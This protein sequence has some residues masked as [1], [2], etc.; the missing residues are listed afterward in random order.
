[1]NATLRRSPALTAFIGQR[2]DAHPEKVAY[3]FL[4]DGAD[5]TLTLT[6]GQ[7]DRQARAIA[8]QLSA[9][10][11]P[12]D[13]AVLLYPPGLEYITALCGCFYAGLIAVPAYPPQSARMDRA[14]PRRLRAI[15]ADARPAL[16]LTTSSG[17]AL[18]AA[19]REHDP[20]FSTLAW[21][22][23]DTLDPA[24]ADGWAEPRIDDSAIA[25]LQYTSGSTAAPKGVMLSHANLVH[26]LRQIKAAFAVTEESRG[27]CWL[28]PYHDMGLIGGVL[29]P[30]F[31]GATTI[32]MSPLAF[33]QR[34]LRWLEAISQSRTTISGGPNFA[35]ELCVRKTTPEQRATLDLSSWRVAFTGAEPIQAA[36][37]R[38][39]AE[40]FAPS[41][42]RAEAFYPCYGLAE[43]TLI[44][45]GGAPD[46]PPIMR[47][48]DA[49]ALA[50]HRVQPAPSADDGRLLVGCGGAV[51]DQQIAIVDPASGRR[52]ESGQIGE[53]W[54]Q[55]PSV[56]QGYWDKPELS[57]ET[58]QAQ[59]A[60]GNDERFL[61]TGDLGFLDGHELFVTGRIKDLII[62]R[63]RNHYP[64]DI[65]LSAELSH[66]ALR[67]GSGAAFAVEAD[68]EER[69]IVVH[70]LERQRL[71]DDP[72]PI[73]EAIRRAVA[74][75]HQI[76]PYAV[77]LL[78]PGSLPKT[79]SGKIQR[80][81]CRAAYLDGALDAVAADVQS[82]ELDAPPLADDAPLTR[83]TLLALPIDERALLLRPMLQRSIA[84]TLGVAADQIAPHAPLTALGLDSLTATE[85]QQTIETQLQVVTPMT[86]FL[87]GPS[88]AELAAEIA[89]ALDDAPTAS[90]ALAPAPTERQP[91]SAGQRSLWLL[92][93]LAPDSAA[94]NIPVAARIHGPIDATRL[95]SALAD[96]LARHDELRAAFVYGDATTNGAPIRQIIASPPRA[97]TMLDARGWSDAALNAHLSAEA[98]RPF[99]LS[100]PP[101]LR[102]TLATR[103][104][105]EHVLLIVAH[106]IVADLW[107]LL[108]LARELT[109]LYQQPDAPSAAGLRYADYAAAH[110]QRLASADGE[111]LWQFWQR[112]LADAPTALDLPT[113][114]PRPPVQTFRGAAHA[115]RLDPQLSA[116]VRALGEREGATPFMTLLAA[117][118]VLLQRYTQQT[119]LLVGVPTAG[120]TRAELGDTIGYFI[121]P[122]VLRAHVDPHDSFRALLADVRRT[123]LD[124]L[125]HQEYPFVSLVERLQ[126][127]RDPSRSPL[128]QVMFAWQKMPLLDALGLTGFAFGATGRATQ[129]G[130]F[131]V[132]PWPLEQRAA[133]FDLSLAMGELDQQL[134]GALEYNA[135][136]FDAVT[137]ER[138]IGHFTTLLSAIVAAPEQ[139][140]GTLPLL[141]P[142]EERL[143]LHEWN[144]AAAPLPDADLFALIAAQAARTPD[145]VALIYDDEQISYGALIERAGR[146]GAYLRGRGV[147][148]SPQ[149]ESIV[150]VLLE[151]SID[152]MAAILGV[153]HAGGC[154]VPLDPINPLDRL[155]WLLDDAGAALLLTSSALASVAPDRAICLDRD[156][157]AIASAS[158]VEPRAA[159][160]NQ[161]AAIIY[162][163]GSTGQPKGVVLEQRSLVNLVASFAASYAPTPA[164]RILPLT[165]LASASF[166]GEIF[167]LL[168]AGGALVLPT[169]TE[170]LD[171]TALFA[172]LER[173]AVSIVST[174]PAMI[175]QLNA[176]QA[177]LPQLRLLLSGGEALHL[178]D[179]DQLLPRATI[180][181]GYG[182]TET[183]VCST[184][185][186]LSA[187]DIG[188]GSAPIGAP[189]INTEVYVLDAQMQPLPEGVPGEL[190]I[191]GTGLARGYLN[192]PALT[193]ERFVPNPFWKDEGGRIRDEDSGFRLPPSAFRLY[194]TGDRARWRSGVLDYLGRN[195]RQVKLRGF[196]IEPG[197]IEALIG[198]DPRVA[199]V[200]ALLRDGDDP[201]LAAYIVPASGDVNDTTL[202]SDLRASLRQQVPEYMAPTA[203]MLLER[204]PLTANGKLDMRALPDPQRL[205]SGAPFQAPRS[206]LEQRI[207]AVWRAV[208]NVEQVGVADNFF[209]IGGHSLLLV[210]VHSQ[211]REQ[212]PQLALLDLF[213]HPTI[214]ALAQ[215][216]SAQTEPQHDDF[217]EMQER[218]RK[219]REL[220]DRRKQLRGGGF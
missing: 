87:A 195:D 207:A 8:A 151:R 176:R 55:G 91:L 86:R 215:Y 216:V 161:A 155:R 211:L 172:L 46:D 154:Y 4:R 1:M 37:L 101:L 135:D 17:L 20:I 112:T 182:L 88:V 25:L 123:A 133:Q 140:I 131:E 125:A 153:L 58:F 35:Y 90:V 189:V 194:R 218:A 68:G 49:D 41:G 165:A 23:A 57:R 171:M 186:P 120:R 177:T 162:T 77:V 132:E 11:Q 149:G 2:A 134:I 76:Q 29:Q 209:D 105:D 81:A 121:N 124:A 179:V 26:N 28:P 54:V 110:T 94:Y 129:L 92:Q 170:A 73:I 51:I 217:A 107:S 210:Q 117:F 220:R 12:G 113:D 175:G 62:I 166:V 196:R 99:D 56:A 206:E 201:Q 67:P 167:P 128:F 203:W 168:C 164:D 184:C 141:T 82:A 205:G 78:R 32:L 159:E 146:I 33:L 16:A 191:G 127:Q 89:A 160:P 219:Q 181:N 27:V 136:L 48:Y 3:T 180:V 130:P 114:R 122:I 50:A 119:D 202:L 183:T 197:E 118:D 213:Q 31:S 83:E 188:A 15:V 190:Y 198:R 178:A 106:H 10:A 214:G 212:F 21:L 74:E 115:F 98:H 43:A 103:A 173:H 111:Q 108:I 30:L 126:P 52:C 144:R 24:A 59:L 71:R 36:T 70:E 138:M 104:D 157:P 61:R 72:A 187:A 137:V 13:R 208:L 142:A 34:P 65:E 95:E 109:A 150:G 93:Q 69:L 143:I 79:S 47:A 116:A 102:A 44:V 145:A 97:L 200:A 152:L 158:A 45:A 63:G 60:G 193:A 66:P 40:A 156:W 7:L 14:L 174:V 53:V 96:V 148:G 192:R 22:A 64:Q 84:R 199:D 18:G 6:Y 139:P 5:E 9:S 42:F 204:L 75:E 185:Y 39:F 169:T 163:S 100:R 19:L 38:R 85:L 147:G 80:H